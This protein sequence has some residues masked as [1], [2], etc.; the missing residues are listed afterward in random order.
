[1]DR[2]AATVNGEVITLQDLIDRA[3]P[4]YQRAE[5]QPPGPAR[6]RARAEALRRA[7]DAIVSDKLF[8]AEAAKLTDPITDQTV[9]ASIEDV[10]KANHL[11]DK[12]LD[13]ALS[14]QGMTRAQY[15]QVIRKQMETYRVLQYK[16]GPRLKVTD[17]D[18]RNYYNA[19]PAEFAGEDEVKVRHILLPLAENA[20]AAEE[21]RVR[22]EAER[23]LQRLKAGDD[24]AAAARQLSKGPAAGDGGDLGWL[25]R[26]TLQ[27]SL[28]EVIFE[29]KRGDISRPVRAGP[30]LHIF[31]VEERRLGGAKSF[32]EVKDQLR[33]RL[34]NEQ[35]EG[36]RKDYVEELKKDAVILTSLPELKASETASRK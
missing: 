24:F 33:D 11:D 35:A 32:D 4:E 28:E 20:G 9:D 31:K 14:Q 13:E 30:G 17:E 34:T 8:E 1:V 12:Q 19:H 27:R 5:T 3:G 6:D 22:A 7:F 29:L 25:R 21:T 23:V 26:G 2:V 36:Y 18:V 15:R 16:V 10:K